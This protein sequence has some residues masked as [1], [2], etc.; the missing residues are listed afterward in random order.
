MNSDF[1]D[2]W[3]K[4]RDN[5][6]LAIEKIPTDPMYYDWKPNDEMRTTG[7]LIYHIA[8]AEEGWLYVL[9]GKDPQ[10]HEKPD[11]ITIN[12]I[13][14]YLKL[15][16]QILEEYLYNLSEEQLDHE[17][18]YTED[19][20]THKIKISAIIFHLFHHEVHHTGALTTYMRMLHLE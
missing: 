9:M 16:H 18:E 7:E 17:V 8:S 4:I 1:F 19:D 11:T 15:R 14:D 13:K 2:N 3:E 10:W 12:G 5:L 6:Y 20:S